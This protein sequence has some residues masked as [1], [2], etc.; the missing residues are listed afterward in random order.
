MDYSDTQVPLTCALDGKVFENIKDL[1]AH[2]KI[3]RLTNGKRIL[4]EDYYH[5]Y[6]PRYDKA[7]GA[8]IPYKDPEQ[9]FSQE[10]TDKNSLKKWLKEN[11]EEGKIWAVEWLKKRKESKS[12][13]YAPSYV[14][15]RS[16]QCPTHLYYNKFLKA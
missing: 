11:P 2:I 6:F 5:E 12:L 3:F 13:E 4:L 8:L 14:E 10:F 16:L 15:L 1:H 7:T 9:Y